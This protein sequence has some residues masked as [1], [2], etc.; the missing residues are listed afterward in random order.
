VRSNHPALDK[1]A[2]RV[3]NKIPQMKP[4]YQGVKPVGVIYTLPITYEARY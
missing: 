4:G 1:E 3:L 2:K